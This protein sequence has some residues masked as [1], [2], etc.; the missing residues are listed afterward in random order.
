MEKIVVF[1]GSGFIASHVADKLTQKGYDVTIYDKEFSNYL[2]K[3]Q[4]MLVGDI[5]DKDAVNSI[6]TGASYVYHFAGL[7]DIDECIHIP[8]D[9]MK[10]NVLGTATII[11]A[12][13]KA[14]V[15]RFVFASSM[16]IYSKFG[17]FYRVSKVACEHLIE[18]YSRLFDIKYSILRIGSVYGPRANKFNPIQ[19]LIEQAILKGRISCPRRREDVR[20]YIHVLD[21]AEECANILNDSYENKYINFKGNQHFTIDQILSMIKEILNNQVEIEYLPEDAKSHYQITPY[22]YRPECALNLTPRHFHD[23][24]Q[25]ILEMIYDYESK[26]SVCQ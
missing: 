18:E 16:Y 23:F 14:K 1:G 21:L 4:K 6:V 13:L 20:E 22:S 11:D 17:G 7:A 19:K 24:G 8:S 12:C 3:K 25:G 5:L 10:V 2:N 9:T 15:K 26:K